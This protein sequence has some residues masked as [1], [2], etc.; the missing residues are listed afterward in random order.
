[1]HALPGALVTAVGLLVVALALRD[2]FH[3]LLHPAGRGRLGLT[4]MRATWRAVG[5]AARGRPGRL[6]LAGPLTLVAVLATWA[7]MLGL[8]W[9]LV[10][11]PWM[12]DGFVFAESLGRPEHPSFADAVYVSLVTLTTLGFGD[13][14]PSDGLLRVLLPLEALLGFALLTASISWLLAL[15]PP[16]SRRRSLAYELFLLREAARD[17]QVPDVLAGGAAAT[18]YSDL[19]SRIVTVQHDLATFP[20]T[21]YFRDED[22]RFVLAAQVGYLLRLAEHGAA[23]D[24]DPGL[25]LRAAMLRRAV[26][27]LAAMTAQRFHG[28]AADST[29]G[30]LEAYARDHCVTTSRRFGA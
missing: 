30:A 8:G 13:I 4:V 11:W 18:L 17:A 2:I 26:D 28:S 20:I 6:A 15:Y 1:M 19:T 12:P 14:T 9:A 16:L 25:R 24:R 22:E 3:S 23:D 5:M 29:V 27:D 10:V 7:A 21:Y